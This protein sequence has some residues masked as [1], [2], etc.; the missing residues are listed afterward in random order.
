M[1]TFGSS[2]FA[3]LSKR[4]TGTFTAFYH[5]I[6]SIMRYLIPATLLF[7]SLAGNPE[8]TAQQQSGR[9][10]YEIEVNTSGMEELIRK[11]TLE[12]K[13]VE[14][15]AGYQA[16]M[17]AAKMVEHFD[18]ELLFTPQRSVSRIVDIKR[19]EW[20]AERDYRVIHITYGRT[21][22]L[23][24]SRS[25][26]LVE[27]PLDP[28]D[29]EDVHLVRPYVWS[30]WTVTDETKTILG[31]ECRKALGSHFKDSHNKEITEITYTAWFAPDLGLPY[32]PVGY[33]GLPGIILEL[34][35]GDEKRGSTYRAKEIK[36]T[37]DGADF[38]LPELQRPPRVFTQEELN[39]R[40]RKLM[41]A[42]GIDRH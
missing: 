1:I 16:G 18:F 33:D 39:E 3:V 21:F 38:E 41:K 22:I 32:G 9:V 36:L 23:I 15:L 35:F 17:E 29:Q 12:G 5:K 37:A 30:D 28:D 14:Y 4:T 19:P 27:F 10:V 40:G 13:S 26:R 20:M 6:L 31:Y 8:L 2:R 11:K 24:P 42:N 34:Q 7:F 25:E